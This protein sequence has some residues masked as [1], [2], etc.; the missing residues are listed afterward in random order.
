MAVIG[1]NNM[2]KLIVVLSSLLLLTGCTNTEYKVE[3]FD[4]GSSSFVIDHSIDT[5]LLSEFSELDLNVVPQDDLSEEIATV[6]FLFQETALAL[7]KAGFDIVSFEEERKMPLN[8]DRDEEKEESEDVQPTYTASGFKAA[9]HF[10]N[11]EEF[12]ET[13][14]KLNELNLV[15][16]EGKLEFKSGVITKDYRFMGSL[17]LFDK[18]SEIKDYE[19]TDNIG[20][21]QEIIDSFRTTYQM[22]LPGK[23]TKTTSEDETGAIWIATSENPLVDVKIASEDYNKKFLGASLAVVAVG[24]SYLLVKTVAKKRGEI[25]N[26]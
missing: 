2:K 12:N 9:R 24:I 23:I 25:N 20:D 10:E 5:E 26:E 14:E 21:Y 4:G 13:L 15:N 1:G 18:A 22:K 7:Q 3:V 19:D 16:L 8:K 11:I 17:H 6:N